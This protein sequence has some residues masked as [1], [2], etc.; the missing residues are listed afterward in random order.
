MSA[1]TLGAFTPNG[2][3]R[4]ALGG[5]PLV[6]HCNHYNYLL[7]STL[8]LDPSL[9]MADVIRDA[10]T[11]VVWN[12]LQAGR[13]SDRR[14]H[15]EAVFSELGFGVI[16]LSQLTERGG[17]V[18]TPSSHYGQALVVANEG[19]HF[20]EMQNLFD[21][22]YAA[23]AAAYLFGLE[24]GAFSARGVSCMSTGAARGEISVERCATPRAIAPSPGMGPASAA[25]TPISVP[26]NIDEPAVLAALATLDFSG[27]EEGLIPRFGVILT[28]HFANF[29][30]RISFE[31][32]RRMA[33]SGMEDDARALLVEAG[34]RCAFNTFGG[35]MTSAEWDAVVKPQCKVTED[36]VH[37]M[38]AVVNA[39]GWGTWRV[40]KLDPATLTIAAHDDYE[41]MGFLG[42]FGT[43]TQPVAYLLQGG[44]RGLMNLVYPGHISAGPKLDTAYYAR[45]FESPECFTSSE[46]QSRAQGADCTHVTASR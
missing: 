8:L 15:A 3:G 13:V 12:C 36:W 26:S 11:A 37:G 16:D 30:N 23:A 9:G 22:G 33:G 24:A 6:F 10:A 38:V 25:V 28:R 21:Q 19:K 20:G 29:Y 14:Q 5:E 2:K 7:Q 27:N 39:L 17:T 18:V 43:S 31:F 42:M 44:V 32:V 34:H 35:I 41:S 1:R 4:V 45:V 46:V 40:A